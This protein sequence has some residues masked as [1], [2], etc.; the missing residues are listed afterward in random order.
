VPKFIR[1]ISPKLRDE[2][3]DGTSGRNSHH[4]CGIQRAINLSES[5]E[6][7]D[8]LDVV[9]RSLLE[10]LVFLSSCNVVHRDSES[11]PCDF[12]LSI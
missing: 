2:I 10:D 7:G 12:E 4:L 1:N 5:H 9:S 8:V 6:F 3:K 11:K